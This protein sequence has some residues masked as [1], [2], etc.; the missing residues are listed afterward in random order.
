[1]PDW[2]QLLDEIRASGSMYDVVRRR[3][4][5]RIYELTGRNVIIYSSGWLQ[6]GSFP[7]MEINDD[8]NGFM[9]VIHKWIAVLASI[10][11]CILLA[12]MRQRRNRSLITCVRCFAPT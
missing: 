1:M 10:L 9:T 5:F 7:G 11:S 12:E 8:K 4:L 2:N 3:Y 6:R